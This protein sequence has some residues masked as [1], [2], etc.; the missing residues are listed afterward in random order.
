[1]IAI[2]CSAL[3]DGTSLLTGGATVVVDGGSIVGVEAGHPDPGSG[4]EVVEFGDATVLPGLIDTH[5]SGAG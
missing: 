4:V 3:F 1:M 5:T 2:R